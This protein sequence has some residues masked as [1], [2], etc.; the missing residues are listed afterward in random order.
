MDK[1]N[2]KDTTK[3]IQLNSYKS[4]YK[5]LLIS[6][7]V[8]FI[9]FTAIIATGPESLDA[10]KQISNVLLA[11]LFISGLTYNILLGLCAK[12]ISSSVITWVGLNIIFSPISWFFTMP[13]MRSRIKEAIS[14]R[15]QLLE[16][17][18]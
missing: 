12:S 14:K 13:M 10:N 6:F 11:S 15:T 5:Y 1:E 18:N 17:Y 9:S 4:R 16:S 7:L 2:K 3:D 8:F